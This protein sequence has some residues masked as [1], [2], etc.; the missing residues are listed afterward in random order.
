MQPMDLA[1]MAYRIGKLEAGLASVTSRAD[2]RWGLV[3]LHLRKSSNGNGHKRSVPWIQIAAYGA[4]A[5]F[6]L[7]GIAVPEKI[8]ALLRMLMH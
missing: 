5:I 2:D 3:M 7:L 8:A 1:W 6:S 4:T